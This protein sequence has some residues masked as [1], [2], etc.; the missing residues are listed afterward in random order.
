MYYFVKIDYVF[1]YNICNI[2]QI[3]NYLTSKRKFYLNE[4]KIIQL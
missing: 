2:Y 4:Y 1:I 3:F